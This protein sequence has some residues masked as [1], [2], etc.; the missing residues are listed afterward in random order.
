MLLKFLHYLIAA[1]TSNENQ[2]M[3]PAYVSHWQVLCISVWR[4]YINHTRLFKPVRSGANW[5]PAKSVLILGTQLF[6]TG[7]RGNAASPPDGS[8]GNNSVLLK[9]TYSIV[10]ILLL[11]FKFILL[12]GNRV[13]YGFYTLI[14]NYSLLLL[15]L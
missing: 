4:M 7:S 10:A 6:S 9:W 3:G 8:I 14:W 1:Q 5:V 12:F 2:V 11:C 15:G 13:L